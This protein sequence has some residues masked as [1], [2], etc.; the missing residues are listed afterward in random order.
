MN[1]AQLLTELAK[2]AID[3]SFY[4]RFFKVQN[5]FQFGT[6]DKARDIQWPYVWF[7]TQ[8]PKTGG[9]GL[10][11]LIRT[12][13]GTKKDNVIV[14]L[15][16]LNVQFELNLL[17]PEFPDQFIKCVRYLCSNFLTGELPIL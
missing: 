8:N 4:S 3:Y 13:H 1:S 12:W 14:S 5:K 10:I 6:A 11:S 16:Y 17:H 9:T 7:R 2:E 15:D